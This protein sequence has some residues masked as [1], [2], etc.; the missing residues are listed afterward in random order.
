[1]VP[2]PK[3]LRRGSAFIACILVIAALSIVVASR[4]LVCQGSDCSYWFKS[5]TT[6]QVPHKAALDLMPTKVETNISKTLFVGIFSTAERYDRRALIRATYLNLQPSNQVNVCFV[7]GQ[8]PSIEWEALIA[9]EDRLYHDIMVLD[10]PENMDDGKTYAY[11]SALGRKYTQN[12]FLY[13]AKIDDDIWLHLPNLEKT[14]R[15]DG[16]GKRKGSYIGRKVLLFSRYKAEQ[17]TYLLDTLGM[18]MAQGEHLC[19]FK[20]TLLVYSNFYFICLGLWLAWVR[21]LLWRFVCGLYS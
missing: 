15:V 12:Q 1:M 17:E 8:P 20:T 3:S 4:R 18:F 5:G 14:L 11:F 21:E 13:A 9:L 7:V 6:T 10:V 19:E 2:I 16:I